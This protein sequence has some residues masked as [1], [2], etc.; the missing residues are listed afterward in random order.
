MPKKKKK[1]RKTKSQDPEFIRQP[2][3]N[4]CSSP[5]TTM[6]PK[7]NPENKFI[8]KITLHL[9]FIPN[10]VVFVVAVIEGLQI[11]YSDWEDKTTHLAHESIPHQAVV[12]EC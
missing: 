12:L 8:Q 11:D 1:K 6:Q 3:T 7:E 9:S 10:I 2:S 5:I 4:D